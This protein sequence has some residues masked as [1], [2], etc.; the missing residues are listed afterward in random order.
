M[1]ES[2]V[3]IILCGGPINFTNLPIGTN[4]SNAMIPINGKPVIG[5]ILNDLLEKGI[6]RA[7]VVVREQDHRLQDFLLRAYARRLNITLARL[8]HEGTIVQSLQAGLREANRKLAAPSTS[9]LVRI[10]L[11][12][13]LIRDTYDA[14]HDFVYTGPV[15]DSRRWCI[16]FTDRDGQIVDLVDKQALMPPGPK[17]ALAGYYHLT[18]ADHLTHCIDAS[19]ANGERELSAVLLRYNARCPIKTTVAE[20]WFDFG[21]I[22]NL[23]D[24]RQRL[25]QSRY[26]NGLSINPVLN[27]ITKVSENNEKL[28]D[29][30][31]WYLNLPNELKVLT[32]RIVSHSHIDNRLHIVQEHYGYPNLAELYVYG[33]LPSDMWVA[34]LKHVMRIHQE[35]RRY[36]GDLPPDAVRS[37][38]LDKTWQRLEALRQQANYW[39][40]LLARETVVRNGVTL[41]NLPLLRAAIAARAA[42][43]SATA[44]ISVIHGDYCFSNILFDL[45]HQIIRLIDPRGSFGRKGIY[46]DPRYDI[47]KLR[48]SVCSL[49]DYIVGDMFEVQAR[50]TDFTTIIYANGLPALVGAAFEQLVTEAGYNL[51]EIRFIEGLLF[52]S[53]VPLHRDNFQRQQMMYLTGLQ[54]LNEVL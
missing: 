40:N 33:D 37:V 53:M 34:I 39:V 24:A 38:Y 36:P 49:Y 15:E 2:A 10:I 13:T 12:D 48:H 26:F 41:R 42:E 29:E 31:N 14:D 30:L 47:A 21:N 46:G 5:W 44:P 20:E 52:I 17:H 4:Q 51:D 27:T 25:L 22:E 1:T 45:N 3:N 19:V 8:S 18:D 28:T 16:A 9:G 32:P 7:T 11:G 23:V 43:L 6:R 50:D 35:F 54:L